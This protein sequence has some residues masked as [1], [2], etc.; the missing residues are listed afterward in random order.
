MGLSEALPTTEID[1]VLEFTRR[2]ATGNCKWRTCQRSRSK[3]TVPPH[4]TSR[5]IHKHWRIFRIYTGR[6]RHRHRHAH[7]SRHK[8]TYTN[9]DRRREWHTDRSNDTDPCRGEVHS[10]WGWNT[11]SSFYDC[12]WSP[13]DYSC[14]RLGR[15]WEG[16]EVSFGYYWGVPT[17]HKTVVK[18]LN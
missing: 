4:A 9:I 16:D 6:G 5:H 12:D 17:T 2:S 15:G 13:E 7:I 11:L 8:Q 14:W 10:P 1:T 18:T 3:G